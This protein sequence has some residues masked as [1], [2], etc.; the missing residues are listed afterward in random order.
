MRYI[1]NF[2]I[3]YNESIKIKLVLNLNILNDPIFNFYSNSFSHNLYNHN[4]KYQSICFSFFQGFKYHLFKKIENNLFFVNVDYPS[5]NYITNIK[6]LKLY[7]KHIPNT[8]CNNLLTSNYIFSLCSSQYNDISIIFKIHDIA[9]IHKHIFFSYNP[10]LFFNKLYNY[11]QYNYIDREFNILS[12]NLL[13]CSDKTKIFII[14]K[15]LL[16]F[17]D[18]KNTVQNIKFIFLNLFKKNNNISFYN[19]LNI[20]TLNFIFSSLYYKNINFS[21]SQYFNNQFSFLLKYNYN[22]I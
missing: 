3:Y 13:N 9:I 10:D 12:N 22:Y 11:N 19:I 7:R 2:L 8:F 5:L 21:L 6:S 4:F 1:N 17:H 20:Y 16:M 14:R 15:K 18:F